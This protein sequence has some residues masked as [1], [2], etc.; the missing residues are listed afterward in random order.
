MTPWPW[1]RNTLF[2]AALMCALGALIIALCAT[3]HVKVTRISFPVEG[4]GQAGAIV[5][6]P[7]GGE[8]KVPVVFLLPG[9]ISL[10]DRFDAMAGEL[11]LCGYASCALY[12][13]D[14]N[15]RRRLKVLQEAAC[16]LERN[17]PSIDMSRRA[18]FGHSLGG[19]T[20]VDA[21]YFDPSAYAAVSVGYYIG[22]ELAGSPKNL[23]IG[24]GLYDDLNDIKKMRSSIASV[25][26]GKVGKEGVRTGD[27][28][29]KTARELFVSPYS[30]HASEKE[31][32]FVIQRLIEW[33]DLS[34]RGESRAPYPLKYC[35][36][37]PASFLL[38]LA[39][40]YSVVFSAMTWLKE[41]TLD[42][43]WLVGFCAL[44][45]CILFRFCAPFPVMGAV[46]LLL[47]S[48]FVLS[49]SH[50][51]VS[52]E[53]GSMWLSHAIRK[54]SVSCGIFACSFAFSQFL[55]S[56]PE[57]LPDSRYCLAFPGYM[58]VT[59][60]LCPLSYLSAF[61]SYSWYEMP[62][63]L[64]LCSSA[65]MLIWWYDR[66][67]GGALMKAM[68]LGA[69]TIQYFLRFRRAEKVPPGQVVLCVVLL[70]TGALTWLYLYKTGYIYGELMKVYIIFILRYAA[71]PLLT[72]AILTRWLL[73]PHGGT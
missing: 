5:T 47:C 68:V 46:L 30:N 11:A 55:F 20:A 44:L 16:Y 37:Y 34:F 70:C 52:R 33:L 36:S 12:F 17:R 54:G 35:Y 73:K 28:S 7:C 66:F 71:V 1:K 22:G 3:P 14:D 26:D 24:T 57:F 13:P 39:L 23:L 40:L 50:L 72:W 45:V 8:R 59:F 51:E 38:F 31:D 18:Y 6:E 67:S 2:P 62:W 53:A 29:K 48:G 41:K 10:A 4:C 9:I 58:Y 61:I 65:A 42:R 64:V 25:T 56:I 32:F 27:F 15:T 43:L 60:F 63:F 21:A 19:T 69:R 49:R